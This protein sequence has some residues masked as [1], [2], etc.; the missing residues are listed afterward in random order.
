MI[1][2]IRSRGASLFAL[3]KTPA[4]EQREGAGPA[5]VATLALA[6]GVL[7]SAAGCGSQSSSGTG[8]GAAKAG[9]SAIEFVRREPGSRVVPSADGA[10]LVHASGFSH[11]MGLADPVAAATAFLASH[12]PTFGVTDRHALTAAGP[13]PSGAVAAVHVRRSIDGL[14]IFGGDL[15]VGVAQGKVFLVNAADV[16]ADVSGSHAIGPEQAKEAAVAGVPGG[17]P[18]TATATPGWRAHLGAVRAV[19]QVD[20]SARAGTWRSFVDGET[21]R[22]LFAFNRRRHATAPGKVYEVSP[23]EDLAGVCPESNG[24]PTAC[25]SPV[26]VTFQNLSSTAS[27]AGTQVTA[28]NCKG[29]GLTDTDDTAA[30][31]AAKCGAVASVSGGF[32]FAPDTTFTS[33]T[34]DFAAA[35]AYY[36][37]DKHAS[38]FMALDPA[39]PPNP[40]ALNGGVQVV[41]NAYTHDGATN[42]DVPM[43]Y[44]Y[45]DPSVGIVLGQGDATAFD[46]AYSAFVTYHEFTHGV[47]ASWGDYAEDL[48]SAGFLSDPAA[49]HEGTANAMADAEIG[50][51]VSDPDGKDTCHGDGTTVDLQDG[52]TDLRGLFGEEHLDGKIW[53]S[54]FSE[55]YTGLRSGGIKGCNGTC[56]AGA[57][58]QYAA[59]RL[60]GGTSPTFTSYASTLKAAATQLFPRQPEVAA[61]VDCVEK[62]RKLDQCDRTFPLYAGETKH[63]FV[64]AQYSPFQNQARGRFDR[65]RQARPVQHPRDQQ[66]GVPP[67]GQTG[68]PDHRP[69]RL[70]RHFR[71]RQEAHPGQG[72]Q[73]GHDG[74]VLRRG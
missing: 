34:D 67:Q 1:R 19:Y 70:D 27:L 11:D 40:G 72:V 15:V 73:S 59:I 22:V 69:E 25:K 41:V 12:G 14:P 48:D 56:E 9:G 55:I 68:G 44:A 2:P 21:G 17:A 16:P 45:S 49:L 74:A 64:S 38:F 63:E 43:N 61:Y 6:V 3:Q 53:S 60:A 37:A 31:V 26:D 46:F 54:L 39:V 62:R 65:D 42:E 35:M 7:V 47:I 52:I 24:V 32:A 66:H 29:K 23:F 20:F 5:T 4:R 18:G 57:A 28:L 13:V 10:R 30:K 8:G 36:Y 58:L 51:V 71:L 33:P 50:P